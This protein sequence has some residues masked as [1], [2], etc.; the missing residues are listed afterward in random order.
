MNSTASIF[1]KKYKLIQY[2]KIFVFNSFIINT[3]ISWLCT[4]LIEYEI[5]DS[6]LHKTIS[7]YEILNFKFLI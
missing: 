7:K 3:V 5:D 1:S 2:E 4:L 6:H